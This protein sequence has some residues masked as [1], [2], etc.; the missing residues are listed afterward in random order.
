[1]DHTVSVAT[2]H[3]SGYKEEPQA[4]GKQ[5]SVPMCNETLL[6]APEVWIRYNFHL[7][8]NCLLLTFCVSHGLCEDRQRAGS[9]SPLLLVV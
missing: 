2:P 4:V 8:R 6:M 5:T 3:P 9:H 1:M 7:A